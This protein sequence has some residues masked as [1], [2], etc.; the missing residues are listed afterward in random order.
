M[1]ISTIILFVVAWSAWSIWSKLCDIE[2]NL[3]RLD[4]ETSLS[5]RGI[6]EQLDLLQST[7]ERIDDNTDSHI[8]RFPR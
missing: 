7:I 2:R 5:L 6:E 3:H 1:F 8:D 4:T